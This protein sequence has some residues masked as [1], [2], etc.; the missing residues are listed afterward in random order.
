MTPVAEL[1]RRLPPHMARWSPQFAAAELCFGVD[2]WVLAAICEQESLGGDALYPK[3]PGGTGDQGHGRG[4]MQIDDRW[5]RGFIAA[6]LWDRSPAWK[7][8]TFSI[9]YGAGLMR[10]N[11]DELGGD[12]WS[13]I[14][15][16]NCGAA[17]VRSVLNALGFNPIA[18]QKLQALNGATHAGKYLSSVLRR[19]DEYL[20]ASIP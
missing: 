1:M 13:A 16:Y 7:H 8:P 19:R 4:L 12:Y 15:A 9:M 11:L 20:N 6:T 2:P 18:P 10:A 14:A 3:G 17:K 5:H